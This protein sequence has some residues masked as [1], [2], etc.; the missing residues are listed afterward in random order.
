MESKQGKAI[1]DAAIVSVMEMIPNLEF[2][3]ADSLFALV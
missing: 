3:L 1:F 2:K